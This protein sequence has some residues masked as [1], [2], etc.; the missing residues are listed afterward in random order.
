MGTF[1]LTI[2]AGSTYVVDAPVLE[3]L[4]GGVV[5]S[6][7]TIDSGY[8]PSTLSFD[9]AGTY[10]SS[11]SFRFNDGSAEGGRS[12]TLNSVILNGQNINA[13]LSLL[14]LNQNDSSNVDVVTTEPLF[15]EVELTLADLG[16]VT[17]QGDA[18]KNKLFGGT[19]VDIIDGAGDNDN[20]KG[21]DGN[22]QLHGG[23]GNDI[24][25]GGNG[26][27]ILIGADDNDLLIGEDGDDQ[28]HGGNGNDNLKGEIGNDTL[29]GGAGNDI[30]R[31]GTGAD[32]LFGGA[33]NDVLR[34]ED[35]DDVIIGGAGLDLL[36]GGNGN[37]NLSGGDDNDTLR[38]GAGIDNLFGNSGN[39][40]LFGDDGNDN[41]DGGAGNDLIDGGLGADT[42]QGGAGLDLVRAG[43][44]DD[45]IDGGDDNDQL[46]GG[47]GDDTIQG[48]SGWD[49]V[50]G[51]DGADILNGGLGSDTVLGGAGIDTVY[52]DDGN[53]RVRGGEDND[54]V[55]GG[56]GNDQVFG[57]AGDDQV[58]GGNGNDLVNGNEGNDILYGEA[59]LDKIFGHEG[60]DTIYGGADNDRIY[61]ND[62]SDVING[63]DG[64]DTLYAASVHET[65]TTTISQTVALF[66]EDFTTDTGI[67][68]YS[69]GGFGGTDPGG[70]NANGTY[71][72]NVGNIAVGALQV[73]LDGATNT[74]ETN[75]SGSW[76]ATFNVAADSTNV[77][78]NFAYH[79]WHRNANDT[80]EDVTAYVE[81]DGVRYGISPNDYIDEAYGA[82]GTTNTGWVNVS[83]NIADLSAGLHTISMG[84]IKN[85]KNRANEDSRIRFDD[86]SMSGDQDTVYNGLKIMD[87]GANNI[88]NGGTG[89]D[90]IYG[91]SGYDTLNGGADNDVIYSGTTSNLNDAINQ[92]LTNNPGVVYNAQTDSFYQY[93]NTGVSWTAADAAASAATLSGMTGTGFLVNITSQA[94][95]DYIQSLISANSWI[96][97][98]DLTGTDNYEWSGGPEA[99]TI[100]TSSGTPTPGQY[101]NWDI[102]EPNDPTRDYAFIRNASGLWRDQTDGVNRRYVI[103]WDAEELYASTG[104][105]ILNG[106]D[107]ADDLYGANGTDI[108]FF[109][110]TNDVDNIFNFDTATGDQIDISSVLSYNPATDTISDFVQL[111]EAGGNTTIAVDA[112]GTAGGSSFTDIALID[113]VTGLDLNTMVT[114]GDL[115]VA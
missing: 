12:I 19:G 99:G 90:T 50:E 42:I 66:S 93:V 56:E 78:L 89:T 109:D 46:Y 53:D 14:S 15:G 91:S 26:N 97:A 41:L 32:T 80:G 4:V 5:V 74:T 2:D 58:W 87:N 20:I 27:D 84:A 3:V 100:I 82:G 113:G 76:D 104:L 115:I 35:D 110:N 88:V 43:D 29:N 65:V 72:T 28:I 25:R 70:D 55:Y 45:T 37:D 22:D 36:E 18:A 112:D 38:G 49:R 92:I 108:F 59:G 57:D 6:S 30:V 102:G 69:D 1:L 17:M 77:Q 106:G 31:G 60:D 24:I 39:D 101:T 98:A 34:G 23:A 40:R 64:A 96:G 95:N 71:N 94:E 86:I 83:L 44:G 10:P 73:Y 7:L 105:N 61:G 9:F 85:T 52:G 107:G 13:N 63:D 68:T 21:F 48:G 75:I 62:G 8:T 51:E 114:N 103:E 81:I 33:G 11:L 67:F 111:T 47:L 79:L 54:F 16:T